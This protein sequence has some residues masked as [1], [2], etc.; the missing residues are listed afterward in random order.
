MTIT[1]GEEQKMHFGDHIFELSSFCFLITMIN[2]SK[3]YCE[4]TE[5][6]IK[7]EPNCSR[8]SHGRKAT[9]NI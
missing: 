9:I 1:S 7:N 2:M 3:K 4:R 8:I 5:I 6:Y